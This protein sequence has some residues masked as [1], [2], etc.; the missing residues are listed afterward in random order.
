MVSSGQVQRHLRYALVGNGTVVDVFDRA[1][2][3]TETEVHARA[4]RQKLVLHILDADLLGPLGGLHPAIVRQVGALGEEQEP[5]GV[6]VLLAVGG[7]VLHLELAQAVCHARLVDGHLAGH[8]DEAVENHTGPYDGNPLQ[9]LLQDDVDETVHL[10]V[11]GV[12][13]PP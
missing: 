9:R 5:H 3:L 10:G 13:H 1:L 8:K 4:T 11:V 7:G 12:A 6:K 2:E